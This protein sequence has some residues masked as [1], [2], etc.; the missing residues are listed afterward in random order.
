MRSSSIY[1]F[2]PNEINQQDF[3]AKN[4]SIIPNFDISSSFSPNKDRVEYFIY[5]TSDNILFSEN[6]SYNWQADDISSSIIY[7]I[8]LD[9]ENDLISNGFEYGNYNVVYNFISDYF[10]SNEPFFIK[11][12]SSDRTEL[13]IIN[14]YINSAGLVT[15]FE[16]FKSQKLNNDYYDEFYID[17]FN[18]NKFVAVNLLE[19]SGS[20]L[21]KLYDPLPPQFSLGDKCILVGK[22]AESVGFNV[23]FNQEN[24]IGNIVPLQG[25]N[26]N[27]KL[28]NLISSPTEYGSYNT[29]LNTNSTGS[30]N[31]LNSL[32]NSKNNAE[33]NVDFRDFS[34]FVNFSSIKQRIYNFYEKVS[35]IE[36]YSGEI[37][38]INS[39]DGPTSASYSVSSS[40]YN[41]EQSIKEIIQNFDKYE[42]F[43]YYTSGSFAYPKSN[44]VYPYVLQPT[45]SINVINWLGSDD[46]KSIHYGGIILSA[47]IYDNQNQNNLFYTIPEY[48]SENPDNTQYILFSNMVGQFFDDIWIYIKSVTEKYNTDNRINYGLS[49]DLIADVINSLGIDIN[50]N[51]YSIQNLYSSFLGVTESGS[52]LPSTGQEKI[53]NYIAI[54]SGS[55][56]YG[57]DDINKEI[58]KRLYHNLSFLLKK[59]GTVQAIRE[60]ANIYGIPNTVL[61]INEFGGKNRDSDNHDHS[62]EIFNYAMTLNQ[63]TVGI[64]IPFTSSPTSP[65]ISPYSVVM[66]VKFPTFISNKDYLTI[67]NQSIMSLGRTPSNPPEAPWS[68]TVDYTGSLLSGSYSGSIVDPYYNY[69]TVNFNMSSSLGYYSSSLYIPIFNKEWWSLMLRQ[70]K[71]NIRL[72]AKSRSDGD[73]DIT[74]AAVSP[75]ISPDTSSWDI[76]FD[77][78]RDRAVLRVGIATNVSPGKSYSAMSGSIQELRYYNTPLTEDTFDSFVRNPLSIEGNRISGSQSSYNSLRFRAPLGTDLKHTFDDFYSSSLVFNNGSFDV[79]SQNPSVTGSNPTASFPTSFLFSTPSRYFL[80][81]TSSFGKWYLAPN[82]EKVYLNQSIGGLKS[83]LNEK[84]SIF[85]SNLPPGT[86]SLSRLISIQQDNIP[87][88][89]EYYADNNQLE[90]A[91]SPQNEID[92]DITAQLGGF[93]LGEYIDPRDR[94]SNVISYPALKNLNKDYQK[95]YIHGYNQW[96]YIRLIKYID[97][98]F[99]K[100]VK[101]FIPARTNL[102]SGIVIKSH[103]LER[104]KY[105]TPVLET[106][107]PIFSGPLGDTLLENIVITGSVNGKHLLD[108]G[109]NAYYGSGDFNH[110]QIVGINGGTGGMLPDVIYGDINLLAATTGSQT[111]SGSI[112]D[113]PFKITS[114]S[115]DIYGGFDFSNSTYTYRGSKDNILRIQFESDLF[116]YNAIGP[117]VFYINSNIRGNLKN[118]S[119][120]SLYLGNFSYEDTFSY[121]EEI[122][123]R[124][125]ALIS[126]TSS[127]IITN[128]T[129]LSIFRLDSYIH[130]ELNQN[131]IQEWEYINDSPVGS[132]TEFQ[133]SDLEFYNGEFKGSNITISEQSLESEEGQL[134]LQPSTKETKYN[135]YLFDTADIGNNAFFTSSLYTPVIPGTLL[136]LYDSSGLPSPSTS[137]T[138]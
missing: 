30:F 60:L 23:K 108:G 104:N 31:Q 78:F 8:K 54:N 19:E 59:K 41:T 65:A 48:L 13:R 72:F 5:D 1:S 39:I 120:S 17:L 119:S 117:N 45:G 91:F 6:N 68:I 75:L 102:R 114:V 137:Q 92:N 27:I 21:L 134:Y 121:G 135:L 136:L 7:N 82:R 66:R 14:N 10:K 127:F 49:K 38:V 101:S 89:K 116:I 11:E 77:V 12:V 37:S 81:S 69:G 132:I 115:K 107:T 106:K 105:P 22:S 56:A 33:I 50:G 57:T 36:L 71:D 70:D 79:L 103:I 26:L 96:D 20:L 28:N 61:R 51:N 130:P 74:Y 35:L 97:N 40:K 112:G 15:L 100:L 138:G 73:R 93:N 86:Q 126:D 128:N 95:K 32:L 52:F 44:S 80:P 94:L 3:Y 16:D 88:N 47:S 84:I 63:D 99:F 64:R 2:N 85:D 25:P 123:I 9:P 131:I 113:I 18:D 76:I 4:N 111:A 42:Y 83:R 43:L 67:P 58:Y 87:V 29:I 122:S 129:K 118:I 109:Q 24:F 125:K 55:F 98:S 62:H 46:E 53:T 90:V 124:H 133:H 110:D 34:T